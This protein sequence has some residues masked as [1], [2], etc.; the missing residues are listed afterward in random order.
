MDH[1]LEFGEWNALNV[2][3]LPYGHPLGGKVI[4]N[5]FDIDNNTYL[6]RFQI[7]LLSFGMFY[8]HHI[9][10]INNSINWLLYRNTDK[11]R[12]FSYDGQFSTLESPLILGKTL[13]APS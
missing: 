4:K 11:D 1:G 13:A 2:V 9:F 6:A 10:C 5:L 3:I 8:L 12:N 7:N